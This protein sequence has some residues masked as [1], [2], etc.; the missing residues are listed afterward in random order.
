MPAG[1]MPADR[2]TDR[3]MRGEPANR[4][5]R[6]MLGPPALPVVGEIA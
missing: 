2:V 3:Y 4:T 1:R 5:V 6:T